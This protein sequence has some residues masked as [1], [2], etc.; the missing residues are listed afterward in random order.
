MAKKPTAKAQHCEGEVMPGWLFSV[1]KEG[2]HLASPFPEYRVRVRILGIVFTLH[3]W[4]E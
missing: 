2:R 3:Q 1:W 4:D